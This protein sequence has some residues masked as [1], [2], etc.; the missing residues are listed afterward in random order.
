MGETEYTKALKLGERAYRAATLKGEYPYLPA[1]DEF[2]QSSDIQTEAYLGLME[3]PLDQIVGTKTIGR[4]NSFARNFMPIMKEK[5]EF[6]MKWEAVFKY[7]NEKGVNDPI[8]AYEFMNKYYVLEGNKRVSV[9][10]YNG[11]Y[12]IEGTVTRIV[13][14]LTEDPQVRIFYEYMEFYRKTAINYI[15]FSKEGSFPALL[16][17]CSQGT[18]DVWSAEQRIDFSSSYLRFS[19]IFEEKGGKKLTITCGD[20]FLLYLSVY[21][22]SELRDKT[23]AQLREEIDAV[24][25]EFGVLDDHPDK[26]LVLDPEEGAA[27]NIFTRFFQG[28]GS[29]TLKVA[30]IHEKPARE[31]GWVYSHELGRMHIEQVFGRQIVTKTYVPENVEE[32]PAAA[33]SLIEQAIEDGNHILFTTSERMLSDSLKAAIAHPQI[34]I[35]NCSVNRPFKTLRTYYGRMYE[36]K[37]LAGMIAGAL[38]AHD[39]IAYAADYPIYG[40][41]AN[42]NAFARG[43]KMTNPR[44]KVYLHWHC[45]PGMDFDAMMAEHGITIASDVDLSRPGAKSRRFGLYR[46]ADGTY[47][48]LAAPMW[49]WG[50]FYERIIRDIVSGSWADEEKAHSAV[51]YWWGISGGIID[52]I[53]SK[54]LPRGLARLT[55]IMRS[56]IWHGAFM[57]FEDV[58]TRQ[59]GVQIGREGSFLSP[60][61]IITMDWLCDNVIGSI[62]E[63]D[64]LTEDARTLVEV[65]GVIKPRE[66]R[67]KVPSQVTGIHDPVI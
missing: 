36:A 9:M 58:I 4:A 44:A 53:T 46:V 30:F 14:K 67:I 43:A 49:N 32:G 56:E 60:E 62:P 47:D 20:A 31:S 54:R 18:E 16:R 5:S 42:V 26:A 6:A 59:D 19:K 11:A 29:K 24:W 66:E 61:E 12:S 40:T 37:F 45:V 38:A 50:K 57:P 39:K 2:L 3:I 21:P 55:N 52:L 17:A 63:V 35:L 22:Y 7:A 33:M 28:T 48:N 27:P 51:N 1:L 8:V 13:P 25:K 23:D 65:Q 41:L 64:A 15:W 34:K 10:K